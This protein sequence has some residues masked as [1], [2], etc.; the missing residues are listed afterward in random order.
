MSNGETD[1]LLIKILTA[2]SDNNIRFEAVCQLLILL[3]FT[4]RIKGSHHIFFKDHVEEIINLQ[5]KNGKAK[6][7]QVKQIRELI[8]KHNLKIGG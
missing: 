8:V 7:Y 4:N 5:E 2:S 3:G 6:S 1:K